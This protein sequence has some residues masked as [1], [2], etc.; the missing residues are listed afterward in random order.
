MRLIEKV[1]F[2]SH[3]AKWPIIVLLLPLTL[4]FWLISSLRRTCYRL[5]LFKQVKIGKP[6]IVVGNIGIGGNG[7][8]PVV[9]YLVEQ[10]QKLGLKPG[11]ISRGYG[12][13][14]DAYP[15]RVNDTS[16]AV[17]AGD[18]PVLI[19]QRCRVPVVVDSDR[20]ASAEQ[21][22]ALGCDII[23]SDDG[24]Q[25]YRLARDLELIII[26]GKRRF[27]NG[28]LLPSGPLREGVWRLEQADY[29]I[30]N[31]GQAQANEIA[32]SLHADKICN[33]LSGEQLAV[34]DFIRQY[35]AVNALAGIGDPDRF[36]NT[37]TGLGFAL[38]QHTG[39]VDHHGFSKQ[40]LVAFGNALPLLMTEKD[41]VKCRD[42]AEQHC[43]Y[44]PVSASFADEQIDALIHDM[45]RLA[46]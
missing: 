24:L 5:G 38:K 7:K 8:T 46:K 33:L 31:G 17:Q 12:G 20:I 9:V 42:I 44:L 13:K 16:T 11:V 26:D 25:H 2:K 18:E 4:V 29:I 23:I 36:F 21:L 28:F 30:A 45:M 15:Y 32:M 27:G 1:W 35:P 14:A 43:W 3:P 22:V 40:D 19:Y 6:V 41:A 37:L 10:C 39:F 34:A